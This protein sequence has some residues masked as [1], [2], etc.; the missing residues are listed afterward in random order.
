MNTVVRIF[1]LGAAALSLSCGEQAVPTAADATPPSFNFIN[2]PTSPGSSGIFR[3][4]GADFFIAVH[5]E[6]GLISVHGL[7]NTFAELCAGLGQLDL[8][9]IQVKPQSAGEIQALITT[10]ESSVQIVPLVP[11]TC[12]ALSAAPV[13]YRGTAWLQNTDNNFTPTGTEGQ[14]ANSF[15]WISLGV[16]DDLVHG[17]QVRYSEEVRGLISPADGFA[18]IVSRLELMPYAP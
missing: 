9:D 1:G 5:P 6:A 8:V 16:M 17:T 15:G 2:G 10:G 3:V 14:R 4:Q 13:L 12:A 11:A 18:V 7:Q